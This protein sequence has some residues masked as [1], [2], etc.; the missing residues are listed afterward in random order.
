IRLTGQGQ[1]AIE[2]ANV[3]I[4]APAP[5]A[6]LHIHGGG[7][8]TK[9]I[10][11]SSSGTNSPAINLFPGTAT[12]DAGLITFGDGSGWKFHMGKGSDGGATKFLTIQDNGNVG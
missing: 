11:L 2:G 8:S 3:G 1:L 9:G 10:H 12:P 7:G 4:G 5:E 6:L